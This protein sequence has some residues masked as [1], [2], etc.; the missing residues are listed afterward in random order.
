MNE[1]LIS[2][3]VSLGGAVGF[4]YRAQAV[5]FAKVQTKLDACEADRKELFERLIKLESER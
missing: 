5:M 1:I 3:I 4:L 2:A